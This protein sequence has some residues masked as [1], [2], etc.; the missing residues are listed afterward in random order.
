[1][2]ESHNLKSLAA[3]LAEKIGI[4]KAAAHEG[5]TE[6]FTTIGQTAIENGVVRVFDFGTFKLN[7]RKARNGRNPATGESI[8]IPEKRSV[9]F[10]PAPSL[11]QAEEKPKK[12]GV[13]KAAKKP[14]KKK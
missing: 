3:I 4:T 6:V 14:A 13:K 2:A 5:L 12:G 7:V 1:M 10:K 9:V 11:K 8:V